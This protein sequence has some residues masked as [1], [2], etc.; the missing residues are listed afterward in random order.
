MLGLSPSLAVTVM[1][2]PQFVVRCPW[3]CKAIAQLADIQQS[4][5]SNPSVRRSGIL[6]AQSALSGAT[7]GVW[8]VVAVGPRDA[9]RSKPH[10]SMLKCD[11]RLYMQE[12]NM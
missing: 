5:I 11:R 2:G 3:M 1:S 12:A 9:K 4:C 10:F 7:A 6:P 8:L